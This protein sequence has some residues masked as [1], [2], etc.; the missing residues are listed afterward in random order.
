VYVSPRSRYVAHFVGSANEFAGKIVRTN[1]EQYE[2]AT[3]IG[4]LHGIGGDPDLVVGQDVAVVVR[5]ENCRVGTEASASAIPCTL[6]ESMFLGAHVQHLLEAGG[7]TFSAVT[8]GAT[9]SL[10]A[11]LLFVN[12]DTDRTLVFAA[13]SK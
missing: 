6:Q 11:T 13:G 1:G 8:H 5:P 7:Q 12:F 3:A 10:D 4:I 9:G 2:V